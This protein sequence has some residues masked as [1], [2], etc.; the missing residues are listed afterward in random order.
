MT[1][2]DKIQKIL[3]DFHC[4]PLYGGH[5]DQKK[6]YAKIL[7]K[8]YWKNMTKDIA[9]FV[10]NCDP[11]KLNKHTIK[12]KEQLILTETPQKPFDE[13]Q[14]DTVGPLPRSIFGNQYV[15]TILC[16]LTKYLIIVA[17]P[18]KSAKQIAKALF[19]ECIIYGPIGSIL[20]D[21]GT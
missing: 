19:E 11:C 10:R 12:T 14:I 3:N 17:V 13:V 2:Y 1:D 20:T 4:D 21:M 8:Y 5:C 16:N 18:E 15:I 6:L 9:K 7:S